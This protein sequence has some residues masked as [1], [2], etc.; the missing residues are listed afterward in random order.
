M[1]DAFAA[2]SEAASAGSAKTETTPAKTHMPTTP[3]RE[4]SNPFAKS[5]E[6]KSGGGGGWDPRVPFEEIAGRLVVMIP[7]SFDPEA[8]NPFNKDEKREEFRVDLVVLDGGEFEFDYNETD[9]NN[10][11]DK[12]LKTRKVAADELP[13][14][15]REQTVAQGSL[16]G[17][18]KDLCDIPPRGG[19]KVVFKTPPRLY[20]GVMAYYP[21]ARDIKKGATIDSI[22]QKVEEW[23]AR[24]RKPASKPEYT[25]M[26][27][28]REN[29]LTPEREA[30]AGE[31]WNEFKKT[32]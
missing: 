18:L 6:L 24:G 10:P 23:I 31:W 25:W 28:D 17:K 21:Y 11:N 5:S 14:T 22:T 12:V 15:A 26:L 8:D 29:V 3:A 13:F 30:L 32:L 7:K 2:A 9:P 4:M 27:D 1:S 20:L 16:I 19:E